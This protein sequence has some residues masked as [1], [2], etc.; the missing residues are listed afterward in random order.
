MKNRKYLIAILI[1]FSV[2]KKYIIRF[3]FFYSVQVFISNAILTLCYNVQCCRVWFSIAGDA[4]ADGST[5]KWQYHKAL[6]GLTE[7]EI[8]K[9]SLEEIKSLEAECMEKNAWQVC[10]DVASRINGEP[11]PCGDMVSH[12]TQRTGILHPNQQAISFCN[13]S[14]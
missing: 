5:M 11:A 3:C 7:D 1:Q 4:L 9:L 14:D 12:V 6:D 2:C 10:H 13:N 8:E